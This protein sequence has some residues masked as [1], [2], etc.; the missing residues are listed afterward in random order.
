MYE[1]D[2]EVDPNIHPARYGQSVAEMYEAL[3]C[4]QRLCMSNGD[5]RDSSVIQNLLLNVLQATQ[6]GLTAD[7]VGPLTSLVSSAFRDLH[8]V[9]QSQQRWSAAD[10]YQAVAAIYTDG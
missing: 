2:M 7:T 4:E 1:N 6:S 5:H 10:R 8:D 9:A 3:K